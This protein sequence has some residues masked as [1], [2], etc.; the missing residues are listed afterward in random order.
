MKRTGERNV[1]SKGA[2]CNLHRLNWNNIPVHGAVVL[3]ST[4]QCRV[5]VRGRKDF[6]GHLFFSS[7]FT[8]N[9]SKP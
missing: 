4:L 3:Y 6:R 5:R 2:Y 7:L 9:I 8:E 1:M